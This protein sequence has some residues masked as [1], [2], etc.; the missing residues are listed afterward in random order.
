MKNVWLVSN[1]SYGH[2]GSHLT[3]AVLQSYSGRLHNLRPR[4]AFVPDNALVHLAAIYFSYLHL[5]ISDFVTVCVVYG[6]RLFQLHEF[7]HSLNLLEGAQ[8]DFQKNERLH[9]HR[10]WF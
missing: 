5:V 9:F 7:R 4:C 10:F 3:P 2:I 1:D 8:H 6:Y